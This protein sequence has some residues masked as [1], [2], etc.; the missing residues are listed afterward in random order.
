MLSVHTLKAV[1]L[2]LR[3]EWA[4]K[5]VGELVTI[6]IKKELGPCPSRK[7]YI[8]V[9]FARSVVLVRR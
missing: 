7:L 3:E 2:P 9:M 8:I 6:V 5:E 4:S 1:H